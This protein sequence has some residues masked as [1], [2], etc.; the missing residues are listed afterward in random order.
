MGLFVSS[1]VQQHCLL[2]FLAFLERTERQPE[3]KEDK[4]RGSKLE[5]KLRSLTIARRQPSLSVGHRLPQARRLA[6]AIGNFV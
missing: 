2:A 1:R 4:G 3:L 5:R 6:S